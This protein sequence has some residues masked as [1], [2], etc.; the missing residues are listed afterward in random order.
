MYS[1]GVNPHWYWGRIYGGVKAWMPL[2][3]TYIE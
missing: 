3:D 2:P 1:N